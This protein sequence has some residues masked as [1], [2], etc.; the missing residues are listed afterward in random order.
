MGKY[1]NMA[2]GKLKLQTTTFW[3]LLSSFGI[4]WGLTYDLTLLAFTRIAN[5]T[6]GIESCIVLS[7]SILP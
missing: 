4:S 3:Y 2:M 1:V 5:L 7:C 6:N